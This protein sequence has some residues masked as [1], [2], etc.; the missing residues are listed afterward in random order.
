MKSFVI[1]LLSCISLGLC[2]QNLDDSVRYKTWQY[3]S[4]QDSVQTVKLELEELKLHRIIRDLKD[5]GLPS[6]DYIEHSA[7][8]LKYNE[9]HEQPEWVMHIITSDI[10]QGTVFR[11]N[12]FLEDPKVT[13]GTAVEADYFLKELQSDST[14]IYD[15][16]GFD[17]G[18]LASSADFRWSRKALQESYFYSNM[19]PQRAEFNREAWAQV[20]SW[21]RSYVYG[22]PTT[23]LV[24]FTA[25]ILH[26]NLPVI[27]RGV[28]QISI[29]A[30]FIKVAIDVKNKLGFAIKMPNQKITEPLEN[31]IIS[32]D[33]VE[34]QLG[35]DLFQHL[36]DDIA[37]AA[38][39]STDPMKW[40]P[41]LLN[42]NVIPIDPEILP[43]G[44]YNSVMAK[45]HIDLKRDVAICG[46]VV[47]ARYSRSGNLWMNFDKIFPNQV[48]SI[49]IREK[50]LIHFPFEPKEFLMGKTICA[51]GRI[52]ELNGTPTTTLSHS[53]AFKEITLPVNE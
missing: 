39:S 41:E 35:Y 12:V 48:F 25:P 14:Y 24:V 2:C 47:S 51:E 27:E 36:A 43:K 18:H 44:H 11:S 13:T 23:Q 45:H 7:M 6:D 22:D 5:I 40:I 4:L 32:I 53:Q 16:F 21:L 52:S 28:N 49:M 46:T 42:G 34:V 37:I 9:E 33:D 17:R 3:L 15:D 30:E 31:Y 29:P 38:E 26:E 8:I 20:E 1:T 19:S 50:D 10:I